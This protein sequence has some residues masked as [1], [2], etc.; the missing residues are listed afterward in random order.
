L[1]FHFLE[2]AGVHG[3]SKANVHFT[4]A[5]LRLAA[6]DRSGAY[7]HFKLAVATNAVGSFDYE[8]ARAYL[9]RMEADPNWP[10][11]IPETNA[12]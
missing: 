9:A 6:V 3:Y 7:E 8:F 4:I 10:S 5:M 2:E 1:P 12:E 11:W